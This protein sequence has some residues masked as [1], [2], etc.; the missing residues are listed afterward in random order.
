MAQAKDKGNQVISD[1]DKRAKAPKGKQA[2]KDKKA[3]KLAK[4]AKKA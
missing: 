4:Q 2:I 1:R 3:K